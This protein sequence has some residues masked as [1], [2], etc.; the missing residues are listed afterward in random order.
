MERHDVVLVQSAALLWRARIGG[1]EAMRFVGS[2]VS[3]IVAGALLWSAWSSPPAAQKAGSQIITV[4]DADTIDLDGTTYRLD[5]IDAP[6]IDQNCLDAAGALYLCGR[7]A[8]EELS[9]SITGRP[10]KCDDL[11]LDP[12]YPKRRI[13]QCSVDGIDLH[14]W[15]VQHGWALNFEPYAKGR[16]KKDEDEARAGH[17]GIWKGCFVSPRDFRRWNKSTAKLLGPSCPPD[18]RDKLF[19]DDAAMLAGCGI[20]GHYTM[21]AWP[22][23]GIYHMPGCGS[24]RRTK[25]K[26][27]FCSEEEALAANFRKAYTC[28][29]W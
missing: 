14:H 25:A 19:P 6:E 4:K 20:K 11:R 8:A 3:A 28:G 29:W 22:Y 5:G 12:A 17:F 15:L 2:V 1:E 24:Y 27:W 16:F 21:R 23:R 9:K 26:R 10:V 13:G 18:A 7:M